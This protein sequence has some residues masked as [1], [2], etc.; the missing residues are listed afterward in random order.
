VCS[1]DLATT[2]ANQRAEAE[3]RALDERELHDLALGRGGIAH[4]ARWGR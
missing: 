3:L 2:S 1:S 4:A